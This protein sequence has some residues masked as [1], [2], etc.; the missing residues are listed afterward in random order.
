MQLSKYGATDTNIWL[1]SPMN[2]W[3][4][5]SKHVIWFLDKVQLLRNNLFWWNLFMCAEE[6]KANTLMILMTFENV[7]LCFFLKENR[8]W[9]TYKDPFQ[10]KLFYDIMICTLTNILGNEVKKM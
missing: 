8:T 3:D 7:I 9:Y 10:P 5:P 2:E 4:H 1:S 6:G